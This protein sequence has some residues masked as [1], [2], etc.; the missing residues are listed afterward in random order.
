MGKEAVLNPKDLLP[1][2]DKEYYHYEGSLT[3]PPCSEKVQWYLL[4]TPK[5]ASKEQ[6][7]KFRKYYTDNERPLQKLHDRIIESN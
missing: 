5:S 1:Q 3:T 6:I 2:N 4:K 7:E